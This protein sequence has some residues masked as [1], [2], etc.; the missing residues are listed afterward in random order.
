MVEAG[1]GVAL[2]AGIFVGTRNAARA[3]LIVT[4]GAVV[5]ALGDGG[6]VASLHPL[7]PDPI[8][9]REIRMTR[10]VG[11]KVR[12]AREN[13]SPVPVAAAVQFG[14]GVPGEAVEIVGRGGTH[15]LAHAASERVNYVFDNAFALIEGHPSRD[16]F[17]SFIQCRPA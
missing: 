8:G 17:G 9:V 5:A 3:G 6:V 16:Y 13:L 10:D 4:E 14:D 1:L 2:I 7:G 11:T 12:S 15:H